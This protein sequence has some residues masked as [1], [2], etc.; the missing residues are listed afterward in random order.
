MK[1]T[2]RIDDYLLGAAAALLVA[3]PLYPSESAADGDGLTWV[4]L[5]LVVG[6]AW[7]LSRLRKPSADGS[8]PKG[9]DKPDA[10]ADKVPIRF[11]WIDAALLLLIVWI[12]ATAL[13]AATSVGGS[14][15]PA[16]NMLWQWVGMGAAFLLLRQLLRNAAQARA[17]LVV[18]AGLAVALSGY[19]LYQWG[20]EMPATRAAYRADPEASLR[21]AGVTTDPESPARKQFEDRLGSPEPI[22]S[23]ALANSLAG[24]LAPWLIVL[25]GVL[26]FGGGRRYPLIFVALPAALVIACLW[27]TH[28]RSAVLATLLGA[29]LLVMTCLVRRWPGKWRCWRVLAWLVIPLVIVAALL[30]ASAAGGRLAEAA[31]SL[32]YRLQYWRSTAE[33]IADHPWLG[34]GPGNF[35]FAYTRYKLPTASEEVAD[36]HNFLLEVWATAGTPAAALLVIVLI[37]LAMKAAAAVRSDRREHTERQGDGDLTEKGPRTRLP[38]QANRGGKRDRRASA[39]ASS[40]R[41]PPSRLCPGPQCWILIGGGLGFPL[42][43]PLGLLSVAPPGLMAVVIGLPLWAATVA[44]LWPW[45]REGCLPRWLPAVAIAVL[46]VHLLAA[47]GIA[48]PGVAMTF[49]LLAAVTVQPEAQDSVTPGRKPLRWFNWV[50]VTLV[51]LLAIA[52]YWSAAGP[53]VRARG[54]ARSA[55]AAMAGG[56]LPAARD[57]WRRA[58]E[59]DPLWARP[60]RQLASLAFQRWWRDGD[61]DAFRR[62]EREDTITLQLRPESAAQWQL[63]GRFYLRAWERTGRTSDAKKAVAALTKASWLYPNSPTVHGQL[64]VAHAAAGQMKQAAEHAGRALE[65]D[66]ITP[67]ADKKLPP[68][69]KTRVEHVV[70]DAARRPPSEVDPVPDRRDTE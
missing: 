52:C 60:H 58:A 62:F 6:V 15:R 22:G 36:P 46:L 5:W 33:M 68:E 18:M 31:K 19:G 41:A 3:R 25:L 35:Q 40:E 53:V 65:L 47:G 61:P 23:F 66:R 14:P 38:R 29:V 28:S 32:G 9:G 51:T 1:P 69:L 20:L 43:I 48:F 37:L 54:A 57:D 50:I 27:L 30:S 45:V 4:M 64:A 44:A 10:A 49:W 34:V 8:S 63:S 59:A 56:D 70:H 16:L 2:A 17:M 42:S 7:A 21:A 55:Q 13:A 39:R 26:L 24:Y 67:H 11:G 12:A